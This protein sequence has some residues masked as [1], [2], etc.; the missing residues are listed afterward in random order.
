[1]LY[2]VDDDGWADRWIRNDR[3]IAAQIQEMRAWL[4]GLEVD[5]KQYP[6][7]Q[8]SM[9]HFQPGP[10]ELRAALIL[11]AAA[12]IVYTVDYVAGTIRVLHLGADPPEYMS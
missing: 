1:V 11:W 6:S 5:P 3:P 7:G 9:E 4:K 8:A 2:T 12:L 10:G